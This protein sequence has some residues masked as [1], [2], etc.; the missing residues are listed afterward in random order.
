MITMLYPALL[1]FALL[2]FC[3][4]FAHRCYCRRSPEL[5]H[6]AQSMLSHLQRSLP[7]YYGAIHSMQIQGE[8]T[9]SFFW[10]GFF[11]FRPASHQAACPAYSRL[12][13]RL[14]D[15]CMIRY[16]RRRKYDQNQ[17]DI[18]TYQGMKL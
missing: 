13:R 8:A 17:P 14:S 5:H 12:K 7:A 16:L 1:C 2:Y 3:F 10:G 15:R 11:F 9:A 6:P 18:N 4:A